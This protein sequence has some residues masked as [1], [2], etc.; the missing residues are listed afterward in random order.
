[1]ALFFFFFKSWFDNPPFRIEFTT[2]VKTRQDIKAQSTGSI[3]EI[4]K[5]PSLWRWGAMLACLSLRKPAQQMIMAGSYVN[6]FLEPDHWAFTA[7]RSPPAGRK[8]RSGWCRGTH[9]SYPP[10]VPSP[11]LPI[12]V[13]ADDMKFNKRPF[14]NYLIAWGSRHFSFSG[15]F[16]KVT[17]QEC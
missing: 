10:A 16:S 14:C 8:L 9:R 11:E 13:P 17:L 1:M 4:L 12:D 3:M 2:T 6:R 5:C 7:N 15:S